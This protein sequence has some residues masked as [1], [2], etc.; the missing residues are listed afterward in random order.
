MNS[1]ELREKRAKIW[2]AAKDFLDTHTHDGFV[3]AEDTATYERMESEVAELGH[4]IDRLERQAATDR[5]L[6]FP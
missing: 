3:S 5:A 6:V 2:K 4:Q 1:L